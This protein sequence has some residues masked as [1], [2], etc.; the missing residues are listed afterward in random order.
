MR[1]GKLIALSGCCLSFSASALMTSD[2]TF[3]SGSDSSNYSAKGKPVNTYSVAEALPQDVLS[4]VYSMLPEGTLVNSAFIAPERYSSIDIDEELNGAE[5]ATAKVTFLNEGAGYRNTLGYFV[6]DTNNPPT[7]KDEIAAHV[8]IFPNTSKAPDGE[9]EEGDTIDLNVQLTAGQ[10]L[11]FFI[12]PNGW[13]WSGSYNNIASLGSWGTPFYSYSNL[14]PESTSENR[15]HNVAFIDTQNE[16]L[17]LGFEDIY[18][19]DGDNDFNDLLFTVEVSPFT[20]I[21]GVNTDGSTDSK[22][23]PLVQENNPEVTVTSVYPSSDTYATMAFEDRWPLMGDYDF[24]DVVWRYRVT[25]LLNGQREI[26]NITFDYTLQAMGAGFSNG[27]AV[28]LPNVNPANIA[29]TVLTRNGEPVTHQVVQSGGEAVLVVS[30]NLRKDLEAL[31][32]LDSNCT[33]YRTQTACVSQQTSDVL[34]YQLTVELS[35]PV[36]REKVGYPPYD[37]FIF[38]SKD[39]YHGDFTAT[40]PGMSWQ[41]HFKSFAGTSEMNNSFFNLHDDNSGGAESF[42]TNNNMPW[43]INIRDE[44]DHPIENVDISKAYPD[45]PTWVTSSGES[46]TTWYQAS[47]AN[48]VIPATQQ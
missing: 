24:N 20:A 44:W 39:S 17:V 41:T 21:D 32:E 9:M 47:T 33:F 30:E 14:N 45:F 23:E 13:G 8:I 42:L 10:T 22:Y 18:R 4:N 2:F 1:T 37:S 16:F 35:T 15:R 12:I 3:E 31:G 26:K 28:H 38:A 43:A 5:F 46:E 48:K 25:E 29:S 40:P 27:F 11:A 6:F 36:S 7:N 34:N 19:P